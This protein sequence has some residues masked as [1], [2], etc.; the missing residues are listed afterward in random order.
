MT[1]LIYK[2][3]NLPLLQAIRLYNTK[4]NLPYTP[5]PF[6]LDDM[7]MASTVNKGVFVRS[8]G[9]SKTND[10]VNWIIF[11]VLRTGQQWTWLSCKSG[12]LQQAMTYVRQNPFV[13]KVHNLS[14][15]YDVMLWSGKTIRFGI[16]STSNLGLRV[17][18]IVY[19]E[20]EDLQPKQEVDIYPQMAGMMTHSTIHKTIYLGTL[21]ITALLNE[22][23]EEYPCSIRPWDTIPWLVE[24]GMIQAEIDE[25]IIPTWQID[26]MYNCIPTAPSGV[27]FPSLVVEELIGDNAELYGL[28]FGA[29]DHCVGVKIVGRDIYILEEYEFSLEENNTA[30]DFLEHRITEA[31]SGGYNDSD[32]YAA[33]ATMMAQRIGAR[34]QPVTNKWK[35]ERLMFTRQHVLH[36]DKNRTPGIYKDVK[37]GVYGPDGLYLKDSVHPNHWLDALFHAVKADGSRYLGSPFQQKST[38]IRKAEA[39]RDGRLN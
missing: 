17:D 25:G 24:S 32:K 38:L 5:F 34:K 9:G 35:S 26:L 12:Q 4:L 10:F 13:K 23:A 8:R 20:F 3:R 6:Q 21:W 18:G 1:T 29:T 14:G 15:K 2:L 39:K 16:I 11:H 28:D 31:E 37:K 30:F 27:L 22:Y 7:V 33:K 19:D 36:V